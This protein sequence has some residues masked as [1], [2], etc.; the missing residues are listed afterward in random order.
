MY[1]L[2]KGSCNFVVPNELNYPYLQIQEGEHFGLIDVAG[3][4]KGKYHCFD[5]TNWEK[6][7]HMPRLFTV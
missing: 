4:L 7:G 3:N 5:L 2:S 6:A 1:F